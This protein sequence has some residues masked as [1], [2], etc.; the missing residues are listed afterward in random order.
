MAIVES[1]KVIMSTRKRKIK[2]CEV[3]TLINVREWYP[4][5]PRLAGL[6]ANYKH[7]WEKGICLN[8]GKTRLEVGYSK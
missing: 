7:L 3:G 5:G 4:S 1:H 2:P 6:V 8:C